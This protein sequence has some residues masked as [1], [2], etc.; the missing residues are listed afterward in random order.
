TCNAYWNGST[1]NFFKSGGGCNNTGQIAGVSLHEFGHGIDQN[2]G[3]GTA[4]DGATG[5][6]YGDTTA[7]IALHDSCLGE[8]CLGGTCDDD[9]NLSNGTPHGGALFAAF[10]RHGIACTTDAGAN[11]TFAG[12]AA[13]AAPTLTVTAGDNS[14][15]LS[16]TASGTAIYDVFRNEQGCNAGFT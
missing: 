5:E 16:W 10:N 7:L 13:P 11:V 2:D 8:G 6:S 9:G 12:C 4:P 3:T 1:L 14:A 15:S